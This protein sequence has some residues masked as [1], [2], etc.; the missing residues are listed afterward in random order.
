MGH[1]PGR[2]PQANVRSPGPGKSA[3][4][5]RCYQHLTNR[6]LTDTADKIGGLLWPLSEVPPVV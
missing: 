1:R 4:M 3:R 6:V 5:R 2:R